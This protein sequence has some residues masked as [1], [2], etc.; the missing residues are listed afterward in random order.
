VRRVATRPA[1]DRVRRLKRWLVSGSILAALVAAAALARRHADDAAKPG[2][3]QGLL[4]PNLSTT[5]AAGQQA[6]AERCVA[7][8]GP[9]GAGTVA[10]PPLVHP[11]YRRAHHADITFTL[12]V[13][14][15]VVAHHWRFGDMPPQPAVTE[16]EVMAITQY[17]RE[18]QAA[19][20]I[21]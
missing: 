16:R 14:R 8:H 10:G 1:G 21:D 13:R 18:V 2:P 20:G 7:C 4:V 11:V 17:M 6:F 3:I 19:N 9:D 5:A 12:A 15:G